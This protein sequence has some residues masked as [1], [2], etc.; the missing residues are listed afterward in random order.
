[1]GLQSEGDLVRGQLDTVGFAV[2]EAQA[3][4]VHRAALEAVAGDLAAQDARL[5]MDLV[6]RIA[7]RL[8]DPP[9]VGAVLATGA[10]LSSPQ[11]AVA[12]ATRR[13]G[14]GT[15]APSNL[16]HWVGYVAAGWR[17]GRS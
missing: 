11:L 7:E 2:T 3:E 8:G 10:S 6:R 14:L 9:P 5:G 12:E 1:M 13:A 17:P 4:D 15:T 16:H